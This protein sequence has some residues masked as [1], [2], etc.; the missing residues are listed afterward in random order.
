MIWSQLRRRLWRSSALF[1]AIL[2]ATTGF[3][4]LT[5]TVNTSRLQVTGEVDANFR[6]AYDILVRPKGSR[7]AVEDAHGT[8]APNQLSGTHGGITTAQYRAIQ[9][10]QGVDVAAPIATLGSTLISHTAQAPRPA[11]T[12]TSPSAPRC[13]RRPWSWPPARWAGPSCG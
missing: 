9:A 6:G 2:L 4:V 11:S 12:S 8:V 7:T 5:G 13:S 10:V 1:G 3:T